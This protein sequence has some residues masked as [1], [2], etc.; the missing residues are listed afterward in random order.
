[1]VI[2]ETM[3]LCAPA[4]FNF[5]PKMTRN[6]HSSLCNVLLYASTTIP[7]LLEPR[8]LLLRFF[9]GSTEPGLSP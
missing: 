9:S 6:H 5:V 7:R 8:R 2:I 1:M 3:K 4:T